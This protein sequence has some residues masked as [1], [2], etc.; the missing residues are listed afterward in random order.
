MNK[1][2][3]LGISTIAIALIFIT[4]VSDCCATD[5]AGDNI[6]F[7]TVP[8]R[9]DI[10]PGSQTTFGVTIK[11]F[12]DSSTFGDS[13]RL[14]NVDINIR[15]L[16]DGISIV[17]KG[18]I[19]RIDKGQSATFNITV[20]VNDAVKYG[21]YQ[22]EI[23][24]RS[25]KD[26]HTWETINVHVGSERIEEPTKPTPI[27][28]VPKQSPTA[29]KT[30]YVSISS[31]PP[32]ANV[33]LDGVYNGTTPLTVSDVSAGYHSI[34]LI[35]SGYEDHTEELYISAGM[36]VPVSKNLVPIKTRSN[37]IWIVILIFI[38]I[39]VGRFAKRREKETPITH[40]NAH[41]RESDRAF[42][43]QRREKER[44]EK[45]RHEK[46]RREREK[47][48]NA[49]PY[50]YGVLGIRTDARLDEVK[51]AYRRLSMNAD[52]P[53]NILDKAYSVLSDPDKRARYDNF[54]TAFGTGTSD[55]YKVLGVSTH[56]R[57]KEIKAA[58]RRLSMIYH[59]DR[60]TDPDA[61]EKMKLLNIAYDAIGRK[62]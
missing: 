15:S 28:T 32:N 62:K 1:I 48:R 7:T 40:G 11:C 57:Q 49:P 26:M 56:A 59:S 51:N 5:R 27:P 6:R 8:Q 30:G 52:K 60:S 4:L 45:E 19:K 36:T 21:I 22:F 42:S 50:Y 55:Y 23:A 43:Y 44:R 24:D 12:S 33:Y 61:D 47:R 37:W 41:E 3:L 34:K 25:T 14:A 35:K 53:A 20:H 58:Y 16:P 2:A 10:S 13:D 18:E 31:T 54:E 29:L 17:D 9:V 46:E 38:I 39:A